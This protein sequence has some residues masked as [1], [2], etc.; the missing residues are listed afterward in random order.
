MGVSEALPASKYFLL[1]WCKPERMMGQGMRWLD[2]KNFLNDILRGKSFKLNF[3]E[4]N[5]ILDYKLSS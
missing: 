4:G 1:P 5:E 3:V 2:V